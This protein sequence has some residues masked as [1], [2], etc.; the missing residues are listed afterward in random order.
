MEQGNGTAHGCFG[1]HVAHHGAV[2]C[3]GEPAVGDEGHIVAQSLAHDGG[4]DGQHLLHA[5][6]ALGAFVTDDDDVAGLDVAPLNGLEGG[7]LLVKDPGRSFK[8]L[9]LVSGDLDYSAVGCQ[10]APQ[11]GQSAGGAARLVDGGNDGVVVDGL[12][13]FH[14]LLQGL[15]GHGHGV[16]VE[17]SGFQE[18][19]HDQGD[20]AVAAQV[21]HDVLSTRFHID[22]VGGV[23]ADAVKVFQGQVDARLIGDGHQVEDRV[24]GAAHGHGHGD[25]VLKGLLGH[26][27]PGADVLFQESHQGAAHV[28]GLAQLLGVDGDG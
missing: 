3:S 10:V 24:G 11:D 23:L 21:G 18:L 25:G 16:A 1:C 2:G 20:A 9:F 26:D 17:Q 8:D 5:R 22:D 6:S 28:P 15:A 19:F 27:V 4:G 14:V 12:G 13:G 7:G